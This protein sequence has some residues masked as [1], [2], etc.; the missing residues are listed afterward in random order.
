MTCFSNQ[1]IIKIMY[2][3]FNLRYL[4]ILQ[5]TLR[6]TTLIRATIKILSFEAI[7]RSIKRN[8]NILKAHKKVINCLA[9][10]SNNKLISGS[11]DCKIRIWDLNNYKCLQTLT[12]HI[13]SV[14]IILPLQNEMFLTGGD[15]KYLNLWGKKDDGEY[16]LD[17][18]IKDNYPIA[19]MININTGILIVGS[20]SYSQQKLRFWNFRDTYIKELFPTHDEPVYCLVGVADGCIATGSEDKSIKIWN[21]E[22]K[23]KCIKTLKGHRGAVYSLLY[24][25]SY[26]VSGSSDWTIKI[27]ACSKDYQCV[28]MLTNHTHSVYCLIYLKGGYF[29]SSSF[30]DTIKIWDIVAKKCINSINAESDS[31]DCLTVLKDKRIV[32]GSYDGKIKIWDF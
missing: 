17:E 21:I 14:N 24:I 1:N 22:D 6:Q 30:D 2:T 20:K 5:P 12:G 3:N 4:Y 23:N 8:T 28:K 15:D 32:S 16:E 18:T 11:E 19:C 29:A 10:L 31:V 26:L 27:W 25:S 13:S 9:V 7:Y